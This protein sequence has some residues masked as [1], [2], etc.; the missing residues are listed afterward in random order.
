[1]SDRMR[2]TVLATLTVAI[3]WAGTATAQGLYWETTTTG[4]GTQP[5]TAQIFAVP[6][7]MKIVQSDGRTVIVRADEDKLITID[8]AR[9]TYHEVG[10]AQLEGATHNAEGQADARRAQMEQRMKDLPPEQRAMIEKMLPSGAGA[11]GAKPAPAPVTVK[12]T[13]E[14]KTINGY[15]C[16]KYVATQGDK[17]VLVAWATKDVKG[18]EGLRDDW[19]KFQKRVLAL[20]RMGGSAA[21]GVAEAY[22][23]I[24]GFPM[25][26][27]IGP[28]KTEVTKVEARTI[29]ASDFQ[30]PAGYKQEPLAIPDVKK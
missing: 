14:T 15:A 13:G 2:T 11:P 24:E 3:A 4:V 1:M 5:R 19:L 23:Q 20:H 16:T 26:T 17:T 27:E 21:V 7:M 12:N 10:I 6:K 9:Q 28:V 22:E 30:A 25:A 18:F 29:P 8:P